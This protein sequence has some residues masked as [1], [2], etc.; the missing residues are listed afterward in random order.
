MKIF[1]SLNLMIFLLILAAVLIVGTGICQAA[2][3]AIA[4]GG[5]YTINLKNDGSLWAWG[6]NDYGQLGGGTVVDRLSPV[7][8]GTDTNWAKIAAAQGGYHTLA[9]KSD[10][11]LWAWGRN[12]EGELGDG[13]YVDRRSP[14]QIGSD[15]DWA[16]I[17][18]GAY[19]TMALKNDGTLWA[20]GSNDYGQLGDGTYVDRRSPVQVGSDTDWTK[21]A[22]GGFHTMALKNDGSLWAW[23]RNDYG[24]LGDGTY[25]DRRSPV[26]IGSDTDWTKISADGFHTMALKS[27]GTLWAWGANDYG[28]LG[29]GTF[30]DRRSPVQ[31]GSD[32]DWAKISAGGFHTIAVK[33]GGTLW[34]WGRNDYGELGD[35]TFV[36]RRSPVQIGS[37][38]NWY[39]IATGYLY[40]MAL[41]NDNTLWAWGSNDYGQLGDGTFVNRWSPVQIGADSSTP[42]PTIQANGQEDSVIVAQGTPVS[43]TISLAAGDKA[44]ENADWWVAVSTSFASPANWYSIEHSAGWKQG[45]NRYDQAP[46][47][48]LSPLEVLNMTLP[49]GNYTFYFAI[50]DPDGTPSGPWWGMDSVKV[51]VTGDTPGTYTN[52]LGQTFVLLSAGTFTMGSPSDELGRDSGETQHQVTLTKSFYMMTAEVTQAQW[53]AVMGSNPSS[54][55]G[56][57]NCPVEM[58]SWNDVQDYI[59][60]MNLKDEGIYSLPT[61]AQWEYAARAG[62][63]T[64]FANGGITETGCGYDPNLDAIGW[65]CYN[66]DYEPHPVAGKAANAWGLYD[67]SGNVF[68]WCQDWFGSYSSS[69][70]TDPTGPSSGSFRMIRGGSWDFIAKYSRSAF[71]IARDPDD[72]YSYLGFRLLWQ[73]K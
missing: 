5:A 25:V 47:V 40:T 43:I 8:I 6:F 54:F 41:K 42:S 14:V 73:P 57:S 23:G 38:T 16:K 67:M 34:A 7:Q 56:C 13:T 55:S 51:T 29:D 68:E 15:T 58:V 64:A 52:S 65:Y 19:H 44:G 24:Q 59:V 28:Q 2:A 69:A 53:E 62:S 46:L 72:S 9:L 26:Q 35:G 31:I 70:V 45:I 36:D 63:T 61:E 20:W 49:L 39:Q 60:Q 12:D 32:T 18:A 1:K 3:P 17:S 71:R 50:D 21:I 27:G 4:T 33:S 48:D 66:S 22:A 30:V 10:G 11:T 37:D